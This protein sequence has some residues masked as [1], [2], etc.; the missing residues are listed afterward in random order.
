MPLIKGKSDKAF[1]KNV[2]TEMHHGKPQKQALAIAYATK[3]AAQ[4]KAK[5]GMITPDA[6]STPMPKMDKVKQPNKKNRPHQYQG[7]EYKGRQGAPGQ[8]KYSYAEGGYVS[9]SDHDHLHEQEKHMRSDDPAHVEAKYGKREQPSEIVHEYEDNTYSQGGAVPYAPATDES[10]HEDEH[11]REMMDEFAPGRHMSEGQ[12]G[13]THVDTHEDEHERDMMEEDM[14]GKY[15]HGGAVDFAPETHE[16]PF[17]DEE[18]HMDEEAMLKENYE[19]E[20]PGS[21]A[22][23]IMRKKYFKGG[24]VYTEEH[25]DTVDHNPDEESNAFY[26]LDEIHDDDNYDDSQLS[27]QPE[28]SNEHGDEL[29]SDKYD[30]IQEIRRRMKSRR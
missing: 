2:K 10:T 9:E 12:H 5:G 29:E 7:H 17:A 13:S 14:G 25:E 28:D 21:V 18:E 1:S 4:R 27:D 26:R 15:A 11:E 3:R 19:H 30:H 8:Y 20:R 23:R 24:P 16:S 6:P 22:D